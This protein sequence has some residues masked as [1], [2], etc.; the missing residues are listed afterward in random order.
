MLYVVSKGRTLSKYY[1]YIY[2]QKKFNGALKDAARLYNISSFSL[3][4]KDFKKKKEKEQAN[5]DTNTEVISDIPLK[6]N[7]IFKLTLS[8]GFRN[9][10]H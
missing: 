3:R 6:K 5:W 7:S 9:K 1:Y 2:I 8:T 10:I 4:E